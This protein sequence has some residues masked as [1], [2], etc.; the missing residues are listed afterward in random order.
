MKNYDPTKVTIVV[1][2]N[3]IDGFAP[4]TFVSVKRDEDAYTKQVGAAGDVTRTRN[5]NKGGTIEI[6]LMQASPS[7]D[8]LSA[9]AVLDELK[10]AGT[11]EAQVTDTTSSATLAHAQNAWVKKFADLGRAK[12]AGTV[13]WVLDCDKIEMF[14]GGNAA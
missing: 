9:L 2:G 12:E 4:D 7:N 3:K 10:G 6:T 1:A 11:G 8:V 5:A 13:E 14:V